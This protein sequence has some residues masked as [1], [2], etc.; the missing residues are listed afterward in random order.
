MS[1]SPDTGLS[2]QM[3]SFPGHREDGLHHFAELRAL[4]A[5]SGIG[6]DISRL[7]CISAALGSIVLVGTPRGRLRA[8]SSLL[9]PFGRD[10]RSN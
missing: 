5:G 3:L 1:N 2:P 7:L 10:D 6:G 4:T 8:D 9:L